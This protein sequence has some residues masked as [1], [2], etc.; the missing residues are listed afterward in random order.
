LLSRFMAWKLSPG[1]V[2][3]AE[4]QEPDAV[5]AIGVTHK[6]CA[7]ALSLIQRMHIAGQR[8]ISFG[9]VQWLTP[10]QI[11]DDYPNLLPRGA[12]TLDAAAI[13]ELEESF[14]PAGKFPAVKLDPS[15]KIPR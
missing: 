1:F 2:M 6:E 15:G 7:A 8:S 9:P 10:A 11:G 3:A 4:L 13:A 12:V 5:Y 14:G